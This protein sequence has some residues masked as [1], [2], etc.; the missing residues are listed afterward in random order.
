MPTGD[1][2][3]WPSKDAVLK[4]EVSLRR[5]KVYVPATA[6]PASLDDEEFEVG[7]RCIAA[8]IRD[9][10]HEVFA[11]VSISGPTQRMTPDQ[12]AF[13]I[14][15]LLERAEQMS[16]ALGYPGDN[17][18]YQNAFNQEFRSEADKLAKYS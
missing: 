1:T 2:V 8:P 10:S 12:V 4:K 16:R 3:S 15:L 5:L 17:A 13:L 9:V 11:G 14:P 18:L 6:L 7:L